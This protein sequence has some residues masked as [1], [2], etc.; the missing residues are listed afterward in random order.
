VGKGPGNAKF[1]LEV[2]LETFGGMGNIMAKVKLTE[3]RKVLIDYEAPMT[4]F[5]GE[6]LKQW[7]N[8]YESEEKY[9]EIVSFLERWVRERVFTT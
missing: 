1:S 7:I 4:H 2:E 8:R 3:G 5:E 6:S 9:K